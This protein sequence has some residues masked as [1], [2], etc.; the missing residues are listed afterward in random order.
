MSFSNNPRKICGKVEIVFSDTDISSIQNVDVSSNSTISHPNEV[1]MSHSEPTVKA[2]TMEG[3][4]IMDGT[5][6]MM[7]DSFVVG[8]WSG[9]LANQ[10]G[11]FQEEQT[12]ELEFANR[13]IISW[14][15]AGDIKLNQYPVDFEIEYKNNDEVILIQTF[16]SNTEVIKRVYPEVGDVTKIKIKINRWNKPNAVA[17]I[18]NFFYLLAETYETTDLKDFEV[19][20]EMNSVDSNYN[21]NSNSLSVTIFNRNQKFS[22]GYLKKM[23]ILDRK[24][25]PFVGIEVNGFVEYIPL[26]T[27]YSDEWRIDTEGQWVKCLAVDKLLRLQNKTY[28]GYSLNY[29]VSLKNIIEDLL[30]S[31]GY[32]PEDHS[33][34]DDLATVIISKAFMPKQSVWDSLQEIANA[35]LCKVFMDRNDKLNIISEGQEHIDSQVNINPSNMFSYESNISLTE[36]ANRVSVDYCDVEVTDTYVEAAAVSV[37]IDANT[38]LELIIDYTLD[39]TDVF[40]ESNNPNISFSNFKSGVNAC[41]VKINNTSNESQTAIVSVNGFAISVLYNTVTVEDENSIRNFGAFE[42][43]H[44]TSELI[45]SSERANQIANILLN[46]LKEGEGI[47]TSKWR[48]NL[49]LELGSIYK[50]INKHE[51]EHILICESNKINFDGSLR[52]ITKGRKI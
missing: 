45:Q 11:Y 23:L 32:D 36:F 15:I 49:A 44:P 4:A 43:K 30:I 39:I 21:I 41:A 47:I 50:L 37:E 20:E 19:N 16:T 38:S 6:Q 51:Q 31:V 48:G 25:K 8:W 14:L 52:Q 40:I 2:C 18:M 10:N 5:Y 9:E 3:N 1:Y 29:D 33:I 34:S 7:D 17:K 26:G 35:G 42:Y 13:P 28:I 24:I 27:F 22:V 46:K 12:L